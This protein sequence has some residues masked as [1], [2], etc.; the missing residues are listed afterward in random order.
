MT[1]SLLILAATGTGVALAPAYAEAN[2]TL[3]FVSHNLDSTTQPAN[4]RLLQASQ[5]EASGHTVGYSASTCTLDVPTH[6]LGCQLAEAQMA[7]MLY[8]DFSINTKS[9]V[10]NGTV[11]GGTGAYKGASGTV[12][13]HPATQ[14]NYVD[15]TIVYH[16]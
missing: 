5:E 8:T 6:S 11:T 12:S 7:G 14:P 2:H 13:G 9:G 4:N 10:V 3:S 1:V 15:I 16:T